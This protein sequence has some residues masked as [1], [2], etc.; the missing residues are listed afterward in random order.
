MS[1]VCE[2]RATA[3]KDLQPQASPS[4]NL[5]HFWLISKHGHSSNAA[6]AVERA[7]FLEFIDGACQRQVLLLRESPFFDAGVFEE[8]MRLIESYYRLEPSLA[9]VARRSKL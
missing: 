2:L 5:L 8:T 1:E 3:F 4:N 7:A 9:L 6:S